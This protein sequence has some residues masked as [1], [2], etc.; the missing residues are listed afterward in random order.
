MKL[1]IFGL[2]ISSSWGNG[3]AT[4]WRGLCRAL[5]RR[6]YRIVF[7]ERDVPYY[8][9]HR[10]LYEVPGGKLVL[11]SDWTAIHAA[12]EREISDADVAI[13]TSY[14][15]DGVAASELVL[16]SPAVRVFYDLDTPVTLEQI[17][18]EKSVGYIGP[19]GLADFDLVLSYTGGRA[20]RELMD[21]LGAR[22][23]APLYGSVDADVHRPCAPLEPYRAEL[24]YI[25]TYASDRQSALQKFFLEPARRLPEKR[26][27]IAGAQY[28]P[29]FPW[30]KNLFFVQHIPPPDHAALYCSSRLT[31]NLT[32]SAM[33]RMGYCPSG[34]LFEAAACAT[35]ILSDGWEGLEHFFEPGREL[36]L[37]QRTEDVLG[38]LSLTDDEL[39]R[40]S[41][42]AR[43]RTLE[44]HTAERRAW[45]FEE[46]LA[47]TARWRSETAQSCL[48]TCSEV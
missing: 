8:A 45:E 37:A 36:L 39:Q 13:V 47:H 6:N 7:F 17:E 22:R 33:A 42:R 20:L 2:T 40:I 29:D 26:F 32:R 11:F 9:A 19:R 27:L 18:Q 46:I 1:V 35:P 28:P 30:R 44:Q 3:H 41:R 4:I 5:A 12:A 10:D 16:G 14:C 43:A 34:R 21:R 24:S 31:L 48:L 25:G 23:V 15:P 38:A